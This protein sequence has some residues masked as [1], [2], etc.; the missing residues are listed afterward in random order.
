MLKL[1]KHL[2][3]ANAANDKTP[4][5]NDDDVSKV[6]ASPEQRPAGQAAWQDMSRRLMQKLVAADETAPELQMPQSP[7]A[8]S[9]PRNRR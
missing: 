4:I 8:P 7:P 6:S 9:Q 2:R 3:S 5:V 1:V